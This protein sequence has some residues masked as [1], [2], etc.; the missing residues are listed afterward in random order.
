[1]SIFVMSNVWQKSEHGGAHLLMLLAIADFADDQGRAYPS[2]STLAKKCRVKPRAANYTIAELKRS[3]E[4]EIKIGRGPYGANLY[5]IAIDCL[6]V[7]REDRQPLQCTAPLQPGAPLQP[8]A[9]TPA[10]DCAIPLQPIAPK[11][12]LNH[13]EPSVEAIASVGNADRLPACRTQEIVDLYHQTLPELPAVR[14]MNDSRRKAISK[15]WNFAL[16]SKKPDGTRRA[17]TADEALAWVRTYFERVRHSNFLMGRSTKS[18]E[19]EGWRCDLD[20]LLSAKGMKHVIEKT[21]VLQ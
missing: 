15:L 18:A 13:Q 6:G 2:V 14:L 19:H 7:G 9:H 17:A 21:E 12:S 1:M 20:F 5:R 4:L 8:V 16:T 10:M 11:P 3:G